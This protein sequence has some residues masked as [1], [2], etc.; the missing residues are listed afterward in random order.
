M[1]RDTSI[2]SFSINVEKSIDIT[3][4]PTN[5]FV[6]DQGYTYNQAG[7]SYNQSGVDYGGVQASNQDLTPIFSRITQERPHI[8]IGNSDS[9]VTDQGYTYNQANFSYN[10]AGVDYGGLN[11]ANH[12]KIPQLLNVSDSIAHITFGDI[13]TPFVPPPTAGKNGPGWF[14]FVN[15]T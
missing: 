6:E 15:L 8:D 14:M 9:T 3:I 12:D 1:A 5:S 10:Q 13:Y 11:N 7:F 4:P 2:P